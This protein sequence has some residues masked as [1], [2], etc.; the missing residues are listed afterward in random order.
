MGPDAGTTWAELEAIAHKEGLASVKGAIARAQGISDDEFRRRLAILDTPVGGSTVGQRRAGHALAHVALAAWET[1]CA[2]ERPLRASVQ[3]FG[4][5]GHAA[6]LTLAEAGAAVVGV[7]DE[8][9][10]LVSRD[11]LD[12]G[13]LLT[14]PHGTPVRLMQL[15]DASVSGGPPEILLVEPVDVVVL[16]ACEEGVTVAQAAGMDAQIIVVGANLGLSLSVE[17]V[18]HELGIVVIPDFVGGCGGSASM[19]ALFGPAGCPEASEVMDGVAA[20]MQAL[21]RRVLTLAAMRSITPRAAA[22]LVAELR[23]Q[24]RGGKPYGTAPTLEVM[25][26]RRGVS[27]SSGVDRG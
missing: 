17:S 5:L 8:T 9:G 24:G 11:G 1:A 23:G 25:M 2:A 6:V 21:V 3:G 22:L 26:G 13:A 15:G 18:L 19:D 7:S 4:T 16:A 27:M 20:T 12:L 10:S 14:V